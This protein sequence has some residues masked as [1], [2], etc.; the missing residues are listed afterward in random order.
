MRRPD[1]PLHPFGWATLA[2]GIGCLLVGLLTRWW[3][4]R[5]VG[6][7]ALLLVAIALAFTLGRPAYRVTVQLDDDRVLVGDPAGGGLTVTNAGGRRSLP[8]RLDLP[9]GEQVASFPVPSL[10]AGAEQPNGFVVPTQRRGIVHIGPAS[11]VQGD[12]LSLAG[13]TSRWTDQ[14]TVHVHPRTVPLPG[15]T[16]GLVHDLEGRSANEPS[17]ADM[18]FHALREYAPGDDQRQVHWRSTARAGQLLVRQYAQTRQARLA[19]GLDTAPGSYL[20][21]DEFELAVQVAGSVGLQ[22]LRERNPLTLVTEQSVLPDP[23]PRRLLDELSGVQLAVAG[24]PRNGAGR[25]GAGRNGAGPRELARQLM[26]R[27]PTASVVVV[28]TGSAMRPVELSRQL[29]AIPEQVRVIAIQAHPATRTVVRSIARTSM[30][31]VPE[32]SELPR[33]MRRAT[34]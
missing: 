19:L 4:L 16:V 32:L 23:H 27:C 28:V 33:A 11:T 2:A 10:A 12:P 21:D 1:V 22:A 18:D 6:V 15:G 20:D 14:V 34:L 26:R 13:R 30:I 8:T 5:L 3:E 7:F 24:V 25:N 9:I 31:R 29:T 17:D